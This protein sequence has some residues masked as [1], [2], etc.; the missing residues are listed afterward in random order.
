MPAF[1][2][3]RRME[4]A[5]D[6]GRPARMLPVMLIVIVKCTSIEIMRAGRPRSQAHSKHERSNLNVVYHFPPELQHQQISDE[7]SIGPGAAGV[8]PACSRQ[9]PLSK[10][11]GRDARGPRPISDMS[12]VS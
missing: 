3:S 4:W 9:C 11:C 8:S 10:S 7:P 2:L 5:W 12:L 6:R 1:D